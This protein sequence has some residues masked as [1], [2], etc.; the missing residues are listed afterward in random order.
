MGQA[1]GNVGSRQERRRRV[2]ESLG[3]SKPEIERERGSRN[4]AVDGRRVN[5][6]TESKT[7]DARMAVGGVVGDG[8]GD[9]SAMVVTKAKGNKIIKQEKS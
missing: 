8:T 9:G 5:S 3:K 1:A 7:G 2:R 4:P 6:G